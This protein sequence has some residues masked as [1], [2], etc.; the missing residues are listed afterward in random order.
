MKHLRQSR[1]DKTYFCMARTHNGA[2][3]CH[4][5]NSEMDIHEPV[6]LWVCEAFDA[7]RELCVLIAVIFRMNWSSCI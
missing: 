4:L 1:I 3:M 6:A 7:F 2:E 5:S